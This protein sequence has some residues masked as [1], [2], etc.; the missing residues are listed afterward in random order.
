MSQYS[1]QRNSFEMIKLILVLAT[2]FII[3][4]T[5]ACSCI[6]DDGWEKRAYCD[7]QFV[8]TIRVLSAV[9]P[10][11]EYEV[12]HSTTIVEQIRGDPITPKIVKTNSCPGCGSC[13][14]AITEGDIFFVAS[15]P[16]DSHIIGIY[17]CGI[18]KNWTGLSDSKIKE[19]IQE[20]KQISCGDAS[21]QN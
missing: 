20:Y 18:D 8:G 13:G 12:C 2:V 6:S 17:S 1:Y 14:V 4:S 3:N 15:N 11:G 9:K 19:K 7:S 21:E 16:I 10:C 5:E